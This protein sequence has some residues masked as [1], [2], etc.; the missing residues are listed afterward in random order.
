[1]TKIGL[2]PGLEVIPA[3]PALDPLAIIRDMLAVSDLRFRYLAGLSFGPFE[4][5]VQRGSR[6]GL[7]GESGSGKTSLLELISGMSPPSLS[8][9]GTLNCA[10]RLAYISQEAT[11]SLSP[12][13]TAR[14]Q[15]TAFARD[16]AGARDWLARLGLADERR[17][18]AYPCQLSGGE[19]KRVQIAQALAMQPDLILADEPTANLDSEAAECI[20][21]A[22]MQSGAG[23]LVASHREEVF[24]RLG[25]AQV[26][27]LTP[28][29]H[30]AEAAIW[31]AG[32]RVLLDV[33][34][35][36]HTYSRGGGHPALRG[37]SLTIREGERIALCGP[38]GSG[39]S[40]LARCLAQRPDC[41][42]QLVQQEPSGS[43]NPRQRIGDSLL[44]AGAPADV[45]E[46]LRSIGLPSAWR[47]PIGAT[48][49]R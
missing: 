4:F 45:D 26:Q 35:L 46:T 39:K 24:E 49:D 8:W 37:V 7:A 11:D 3:L 31:K 10:G 14:E 30:G 38:S 29:E 28:L 44:E 43:L 21:A 20:F 12:F 18:R 34:E 2:A 32:S 16:K 40:T 9:T 33:R 1:M 27:R 25:C 22:L 47:T 15:V 36:S 19:R 17:Q 23:V 13:L 48:R 41:P 42:V 5:A 6:I